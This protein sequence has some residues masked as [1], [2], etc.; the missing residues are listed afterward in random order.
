METADPFV[1]ETTTPPDV[2]KALQWQSGKSLEQVMQA[3]EDIVSKLELA[4]SAMWSFGRCD[5]WLNGSDM[6]VKG[7]SRI[8]NGPMV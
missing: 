2:L 6:A 8:V 3:R 7:V 1:K 4:G 5:D